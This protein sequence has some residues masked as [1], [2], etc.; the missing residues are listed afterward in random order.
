MTWRPIETAPRD[1]TAVLLFC[2]GQNCWN[3]MT[4]M[5]DI[6]VGAWGNGYE[7]GVSNKGYDHCTW[8]SDYGEIEGGYESTGDYFVLQP[9]TPTHWAS[10]P[11][12]PKETE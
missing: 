7:A 5:P 2:P 4:G 3:R 12:P 9:I 6:M 8:Y 11:E 10:L 1:G